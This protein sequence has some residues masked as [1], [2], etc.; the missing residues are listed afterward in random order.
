MLGEFGLALEKEAINQKKNEIH[1]KAKQEQ[2]R[3]NLLRA[4]SHDLRTPLTAISGNA[5]ILMTNNNLLNLDKRMQLYTDIYDDAMWLI[6]LVENLLSVTRLDHASVDINMQPELL[7]DVIAEA[8]KHVNRKRNQYHIQVTLSDDLLMAQM[9]ARLIIQVIINMVDNAIKY[10]DPGTAIRINA[11][12]LNP[13]EI[14][15]E[16]SDDGNGISDSDKIKIFD[17]F[18]TADHNTGDNRRGMG[19]GLPLCQSIINAHGGE[20][21]VRD[22]I[23]KGTVF[24]F[25]LKSQEAKI[26]E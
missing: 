26:Y 14:M 8:L 2:L 7:D 12:D 11:Y 13:E 22:N 20:I 1:T 21:S 15:V 6:N 4:I 18:F 10:T 24:A 9:D 25:T 3:A 23:P 5:D 17:M 16:I 19:L